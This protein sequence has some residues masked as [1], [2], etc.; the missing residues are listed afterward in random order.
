[1]FRSIDYLDWIR[2]RPSAATHDLGSSDLDPT[3]RTGGP[4]VVPPR[5]RGLPAADRPV[6][7]LVA[8]E[9][10][11]SPDHV[12]VTA[13]ATHANFL[14]AG[15]ALTRARERDG[16]GTPRVLV[17]SPGYE[18]LVRTPAALG[19]RVARF[20]RADGR[21]LTPDRVRGALAGDATG[22]DD[23]TQTAAA[24]SAA[25]GAPALVTVSNRHNP[26]GTVADRETLAAVAD[27][28][29][30]RDAVFHV[31]EVY[32]PYGEG[33]ADGRTAFGGPT[34]A[35]LPNTVVTGSLTKF[36]GLGGVRLG[37]AVG[38]PRLIERVRQVRS[39]VP[40]VAEPSR[41]LARRFFAARDRLVETARR[42][43]RAN[44]AALAEFCDERSDVTATLA[45][46][47]PFGL[48]AH[49]RVDG[50]E[51]A[52]AA[53]DA[54]VLVVPG[55]FFDRPAAVRVSLGRAPEDCR[56]ALSALGGVCDGL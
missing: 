19:G 23:T 1:M 39:Y 43:C 34:A 21:R 2:G 13:G 54:G 55:R 9:Y 25:D 47:C 28:V 52:A 24:A 32:A 30:A 4:D 17:E 7:A 46:Q 8:D 5:L 12:A 37:W 27:A 15:A 49:D 36:H 45:P 29:A 26:T 3:P 38:P 31:D 20:D 44:A 41:A 56:A 42:H 11:V 16:T 22:A 10:G 35:G 6:A 40:G 18:P 14:L 50:D 48:L 53:D 33:G 51:L